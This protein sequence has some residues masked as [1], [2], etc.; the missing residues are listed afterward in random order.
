MLY[1]MGKRRDA[2]CRMCGE[3]DGVHHSLNGC[4][5]MMGMITLRH[6]ELG[7]TVYKTV[8]KGRLGA[9]VFAQD[10]GRHNAAET[11]AQT[12]AIC[13]R[14]GSALRAPRPLTDVERRRLDRYRPDIFMHPA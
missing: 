10:I 9:S 5:G 3:P 8:A 6:N 13:T 1:R 7:G 12:T 2:R 4:P 11:P 14:I